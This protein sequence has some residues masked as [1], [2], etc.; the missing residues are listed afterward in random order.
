MMDS[1]I[2]PTNTL[3]SRQNSGAGTDKN[4]FKN[5]MLHLSYK[6]LQLQLFYGLAELDPLPLFLFG[7]KRTSEVNCY[8]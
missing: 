1:S 4:V 8:S 6:R 3:L 7:S 2:H 5:K